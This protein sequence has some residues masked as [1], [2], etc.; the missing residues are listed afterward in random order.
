MKSGLDINSN[1]G[2]LDDMKALIIDVPLPP[3]A[4]RN[5]ENSKAFFISLSLVKKVEEMATTFANRLFCHFLFTIGKISF[6]VIY[7][8][9]DLDIFAYIV[10]NQ[11][12]LDKFYK[13]MIDTKVLKHFTADYQ[14]YIAYARDIKDI[15]IDISK[16]NAIHVQFDIGSISSMRPI[17]IQT[18]I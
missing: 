17:I 1:N 9:I 11:Y 6:N 3:S 12:F 8:T 10:I 4:I 16:T 15:T 2:D 13:I 14:Q 5:N 7:N 18:P